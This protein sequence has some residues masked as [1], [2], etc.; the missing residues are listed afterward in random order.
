MF[1]GGRRSLLLEALKKER[2]MS[3]LSVSRIENNPKYRELV[4]ARDALAWTLTVLV[5]IIYFGFILLVA[6][7]PG[8]LTQPISASSVIPVGIPVGVGV[9]LASVIL[10]GI[11]VRRANN[12]FDPLIRQIIQEA[13]K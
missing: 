12:T 2:A 6:F 11:Y 3:Q 8:F 4:K 5:L 10:T 9:I 13:S 7:A 1:V